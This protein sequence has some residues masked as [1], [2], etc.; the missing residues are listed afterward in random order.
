MGEL[1]AVYSPRQILTSCWSRPAIVGR[2][3]VF[4]ERSSL[5]V[6]DSLGVPGKGA[7]TMLPQ[8]AE[9][10]DQVF[11]LTEAYCCAEAPTVISTT[12]GS[13]VAVCLWD[14]VRR[15]GGM[16]HFVLP[17]TPVGSSE[18]SLR[19]GDVA[20]DAL[21]QAIIDLG[22]QRKHLRASVFGGANVLVTHGS[23]LSVGSANVAFALDRL[24]ALRLPVMLRDTGGSRGMTLRFRTDTGQ[25]E[26]RRLYRPAAVGAV[27]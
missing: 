12:L 16:N 11:L 6:H 14:C 24:A 23:G 17:A 27:A 8:I 2:S 25:S 1:P 26:V 7:K 4:Q 18:P 5:N 3:G 10:P 9:S 22:S 20:V 21:V 19:Y 15:A 13:C